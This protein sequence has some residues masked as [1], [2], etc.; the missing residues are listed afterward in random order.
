MTD[1]I[2]YRDFKKYLQNIADQ[3]THFWSLR[4]L[5]GESICIPA[6]TALKILDNE[7]MKGILSAFPKEIRAELYVRSGEMCPLGEWDSGTVR[8][9]KSSEQPKPQ[10]KSEPD[11]VVDTFGEEGSSASKIYIFLKRSDRGVTTKELCEVVDESIAGVNNI[12]RGMVKKG[13]VQRQPIED[14]QPGGCRFLYRA[15]ENQD[16]EQD[17]KPARKK[18]RVGAKSKMIIDFLNNKWATS[19]EVSIAVRTS[20]RS[21]TH[22]LNNLIK[23]GLVERSSSSKHI[24]RG[25]KFIYKAVESAS[26]QHKKADKKFRINKG[27][28][29]HTIFEFL[30]NSDRKATY[31]DVAEGTGIPPKSVAHVLSALYKHGIVKRYERYEG[32][33]YWVEGPA[34]QDTEQAAEEAS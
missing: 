14:L 25:C 17:S 10:E 31:K 9:P 12:L 18:H 16:T 28:Q 2:K 27:T 11:I 15:A 23:Q 33:L 7:E 22:T 8:K 30:Q 6:N 4:E 20:R 26:E 21:V 1:V 24:H 32:S 29:N 13:V 34:N 19:V 3:V 5:G